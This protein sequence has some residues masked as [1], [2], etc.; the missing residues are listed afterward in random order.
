MEQSRGSV[1]G[2]FLILAG[3]QPRER[4]PLEIPSQLMSGMTQGALGFLGT[5]RSATLA[6]EVL[7]RHTTVRPDGSI[8]FN[9]EEAAR[10]F[11][12][13]LGDSFTTPQKEGLFALS[14]E[15]YLRTLFT[16]G[17][18]FTHRA[19][20]SGDAE[21]ERAGL[22]FGGSVG[23]ELSQLGK[24]TIES[25]QEDYLRGVLKGLTGQQQED[26]LRAAQEC[27]FSSGA[28]FGAARAAGLDGKQSI[29]MTSANLS[30][31]DM[32]RQNATALATQ[33]YE[34]LRSLYDQREEDERSRQEFYRIY[35]ELSGLLG[36]DGSV[37][38]LLSLRDQERD[39]IT[40]AIRGVVAGTEAAHTGRL[41]ESIPDRRPADEVLHSPGRRHR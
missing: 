39:T 37:N 2:L 23:V 29:T 24:G 11:S 13:T 18:Q 34:E 9:N 19:A 16:S 12:R 3:Q 31:M 35:R 40:N 1:Q 28:V 27:G 25:N 32:L 15:L 14:L 4:P 20:Q 36:G 26:A 17:V 7:H 30:V 10:D 21:A 8:T 5:P 22:R 6:V 33:R 38:Y 41:N